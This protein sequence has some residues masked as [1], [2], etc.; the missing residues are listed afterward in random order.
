MAAG[1]SEGSVSRALA[2]DSKLTNEERRYFL[3]SLVGLHHPP[4]S[5]ALALDLAQQ[6]KDKGDSLPLYFDLLRTW[7]RDLLFLQELQQAKEQVIH[8]D[9]LPALERHQT[10]L[11][12]DHIYRAI[13]TIESATTAL[14]R[15]AA[16]LLTLEN[17]FLTLQFE[18]A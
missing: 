6:L 12:T 18:H 4:Q 11:S 5:S 3:Q 10:F 8:R 17:M 9:L 1:L 14:Q 16:P 13:R 2:L 15:R 7:Y